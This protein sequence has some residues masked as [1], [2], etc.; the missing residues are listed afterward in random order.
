[1]EEPGTLLLQ[2]LKS[3]SHVGLTVL[4][5]G[6]GRAQLPLEA[7]RKNPSPG[8]IEETQTQTLKSIKIIQGNN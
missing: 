6:V 8:E 5:T 7:P 4:R 3:E 2:V 1:M